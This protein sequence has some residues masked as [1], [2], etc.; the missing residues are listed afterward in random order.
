VSTT[1]THKKG[2]GVKSRTGALYDEMVG[3]YKGQWGLG[4]LSASGST[5]TID[6]AT[7]RS[8][9]GNFMRARF[10]RARTK[11]SKS[12]ISLGE[13]EDMA[14]PKPRR[15]GAF[16]FFQHNHRDMFQ[17]ALDTANEEIDALQ[18][19]GEANRDARLKAFRDVSTACW[20][21][22]DD[23]FHQQVREE[24]EAAFLEAVADRE[25]RLS[26]HLSE[27]VT[28]EVLEA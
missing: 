15:L 14:G 26:A 17:D 6:E 28:D 20:E 24:R 19:K 16:Q 25:E 27:D 3:D 1:K 4:A 12:L 5:P 9:I 13:A 23:E 2:T 22:Q 11:T 18:L 10:Q 7:L 8:S 21:E